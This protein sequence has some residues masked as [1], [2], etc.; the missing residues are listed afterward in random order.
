MQL[1]FRILAEFHHRGEQVKYI[2][3]DT[4]K[5]GYEKMISSSPV[6]RTLQRLRLLRF[7]FK[8]RTDSYTSELDG[9]GEEKFERI[10]IYAPLLTFMLRTY[11]GGER[12]WKAFGH[13]I[14]P[15]F[16]RLVTA[17][18][19]PTKK[20]TKKSLVVFVSFA[21]GAGVALYFSWKRWSNK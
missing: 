18:G 21:T 5:G 1:Y 6:L 7:I 13:I 17:G 19:A 20:S 10:V 8:P 4:I 9:G 2:I 16:R 11:L 15:Q 14:D 12:L 3:C